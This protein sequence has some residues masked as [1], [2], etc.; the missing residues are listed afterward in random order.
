MLKCGFVITGR[1]KKV[2]ALKLEKLSIEED[3]FNNKWYQIDNQ[4]LACNR[5]DLAKYRKKVQSAV[6]YG[7]KGCAG[8]LNDS[9]NESYTE[10]QMTSLHCSDLENNTAN[11]VEGELCCAGILCGKANE[12][13]IFIAKSL[14]KHRCCVCRK[15]MHGGLCGAE[16]STILVQSECSLNS[17]ICHICINNR[18]K[19]INE[20]ML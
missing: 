1:P 19:E 17:V 20:G 8:K 16:A 15:A 7:I 12:A 5:E 18:E 4:I 3:S 13:T 11:E 10:N 14:I 9:A 2:W 6:Q